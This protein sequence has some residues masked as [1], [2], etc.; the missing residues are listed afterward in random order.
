MSTGLNLHVLQGAGC[1]LDPA[2]HTRQRERVLGLRSHVERVDE[3]DGVLAISF[4]AGVDRALVDEFVAVEGECCSFLTLGYDAQG[5]VLRI[6]SR[7]DEKVDVVKGFAAVFQG[8]A[9]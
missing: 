3:R 8:S 6:S 7:E 4:G 2:G 5:R 9:S 1:T